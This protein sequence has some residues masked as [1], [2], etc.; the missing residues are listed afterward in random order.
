MVSPPIQ[1]GVAADPYL[2]PRRISRFARDK[3]NPMTPFYKWKTFWTAI[4]A[5]AT[6]IGAYTAGE[7]TLAQL[8][9]LVAT[10]LLAVFLRHGIAKSE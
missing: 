6:A 1:S 4:A 7:M 10:S 2:S 9:Q 8:L 3:E 5:V